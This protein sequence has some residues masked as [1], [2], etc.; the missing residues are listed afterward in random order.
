V[1][2]AIHRLIED[3]VADR[4]QV[5]QLFSCA[6]TF[7]K[8]GTIFAERLA[9]KRMEPFGSIFSG[10]GGMRATTVLLL[11]A[12]VVNQSADAQNR[13]VIAVSN[14]LDGKGKVFHDTRIVVTGS[15]IVAIDPKTSP[16]DYDLR[17]LT[18]MPGWIDAH[19]HITSSFGP[20]GKNAGMG[21][22]TP[23][24]AYRTAANAYATLLA[25]FTTIQSM[26][27]VLALREVAARGGLPAPRILTVVEPLVGR[28]EQTGTPDDVRAF[29]RKQKEAGADFLKIYA[30]GGMRQTAQTIPQPVL[31]AACDE[32]HKLGL[33]ALVHANYDAVRGS[34][35][36]GCTQIEHGL[37][38]TD[39]D[40]HAMAEKGIYFDPQA[41]EL[42]Q[43]YLDNRA[44]Y[45][46]TPFFPKTPQ[47]FEPM[48]ELLPIA[49]ETIQRAR[50][51]PGLKIVFG[52]DALAG[53]HGHNAE[54]LINRVRE[55]GIAPMAA[56]VSANSLAAEAIQMADQIGALAPGLE[57]DIIALD[58]DPL[59]DITA[60]R[61]V[62]FVMRSGVVYRN[63]SRP[64]PRR[65][66]PVRS[67]E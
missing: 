12:M 61:R 51:I 43:N 57:A 25:G 52:T 13:V 41:G 31:D 10:G 45:A 14:A 59:K 7:G 44:R 35:A 53:M 32:A 4:L 16:I 42:I 18:V 24:A 36:A 3:K 33:R 49:H 6:K 8:S 20:D 40:L 64:T 47:E 26:D 54:D 37:G 15:K 55:G 28:G 63:E 62:V 60:V 5:R 1:K 29:V 21:A 66:T 34:I 48:K 9:R 19:V 39:A 38:A 2:S 11:L 46:G 65:G 56:L 58:G 50:Q 27:G 22:A 30:S 17:G 67:V 23:E